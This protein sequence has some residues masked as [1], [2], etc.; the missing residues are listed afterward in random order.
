MVLRRQAIL[1]VLL[2]L[3][4]TLALAGGSQSESGKTLG[5]I[6]D[7]VEYMVDEDPYFT[8]AQRISYIN[9]AIQDVVWQT[10]CMESGTHFVLTAGTTEYALSGVSYLMI[11]DVSWLDS[12]ATKHKPLLR[13]KTQGHGLSIGGEEKPA[14]WYERAGFLG[15]FPVTSEDVT[16]S[17][18]YVTYVPA[19][20]TL[21]STDNVPTP[22]SLDQALVY[23]AAARCFARDKQWAAYQQMMSLYA[24]YIQRY[25]LMVSDPPPEMK[26]QQ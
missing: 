16:G 12:G 6:E 19:Q 2:L 13:R 11:T 9:A 8:S 26:S 22:A 3:F 20:S 17:T 7:Y 1:W 15:V 23:Y 18:A 24:Q 4:P 5:D 14:W 10:R 21:S 25:R